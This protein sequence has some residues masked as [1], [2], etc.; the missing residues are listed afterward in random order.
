[1][2]TDEHVVPF[3]IGGQHVIRKASC[4]MCADITKK[5][6]QDVAR[7]LWGDARTSYGAPTR[8]KN[9]RAKSFLLKDPKGIKADLS[10]L[11]EH[12]PAP[13]IFYRMSAAGILIGVDSKID[14]SCEWELI[15]ITDEARLKAFE[16][17]Y[18]GR[19]IGRF[20]NV[21]RSFGRVLAKIGFCHA[22]TALDP[23]DFVPICLPYIL[24]K[25]SN[26]SYIVGSNSTESP[27]CDFGYVLRIIQISAEEKTLIV[28]EV[29][30]VANNAT[31]TYHVVV[32]EV[33]GKENMDRINAKI[34]AL[35]PP[36]TDI[37]LDTT[38]ALASGYHWI[39]RVWPL[40]L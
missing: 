2:L 15:A 27:Q 34:S 33:H 40:K 17:E 4:L 6:E 8:R 20:K 35:E 7:G 23:G 14:R 1:M 26:V 28:V 18:P 16:Q 21:P 24:G 30:L 11:A 19:L 32:G 29:R 22:M 5:F 13:M 12:Y 36:T 39:P 3:F 10:I 31:P 38:T 25:K 37:S 9:E